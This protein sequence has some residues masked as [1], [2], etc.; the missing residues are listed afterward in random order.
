MSMNQA[1][2]IIQNPEMIIKLA[3]IAVV[4]L[5]IV[6]LPLTMAVTIAFWKSENPAN[7]F[8]QL[9]QQTD[10]LKMVTVI[11]VILSVTVLAFFGVIDSSGAIG[12]LGGVVGYVLG[13]LK[14]DART[15]IRRGN[16]KETE[17]EKGI[18]DHNNTPAT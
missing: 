10:A 11:L 4:A 15:I 3:W 8:S 18:E 7:S 14:G 2:P 1:N 5:G 9:F 17:I 6:A 12:I 13:G 16:K